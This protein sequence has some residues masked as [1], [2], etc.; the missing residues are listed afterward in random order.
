MQAGGRT[1]TL[2][3]VTTSTWLGAIC[4]VPVCMVIDA[5]ERARRAVAYLRARHSAS[6]Q[7]VWFKRI[8]VTTDKQ[9]KS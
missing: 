8:D 5:D 4:H 6:D 2:A 1:D 9:T 3:G 7:Q